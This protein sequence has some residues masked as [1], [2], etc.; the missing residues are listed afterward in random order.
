MG[1]KSIDDEPWYKREKAAREMGEQYGVDYKDYRTE[2]RGTGNHQDDFENFEQAVFN[3]ASNDYDTRRSIEAAKLSGFEG[4]A[5]LENGL[6]SL[7]GLQAATQFMRG[8]HENEL[9]NS[10]K[11]SSANDYG[12]V[13]NYLVNND[14]SQF[15]DELHKS[16]GDYVEENQPETADPVTQQAKPIEYSPELKAAHSRVSEYEK[17]PSGANNVFEASLPQG[18]AETTG[19]GKS[20]RNEAAQSFA[21]SF[22]LDL[23]KGIK[24]G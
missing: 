4:A 21:D 7:Q 12:N 1:K 3:K 20:Q 13:T 8:I 11:F 6:D 5:D 18:E 23:M 19:E 2:G 16:F 22:K 24:L 17:G 14:R 10:G 9:E 15:K